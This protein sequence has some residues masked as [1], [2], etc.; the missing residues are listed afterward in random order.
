MINFDDEIKVC[1]FCDVVLCPWHDTCQLLYNSCMN[2]D[3]KCDINT[4]LSQ[5]TQ[6]ISTIWSTSFNSSDAN[7][8]SMVTWEEDVQRKYIIIK[9]F[10]NNPFSTR[11]EINHRLIASRTV[12]YPL[13]N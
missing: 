10:Q 2:Q 11:K 8:W 13:N 7:A 9:H 3:D 1:C 12:S 5:N 6:L 4:K